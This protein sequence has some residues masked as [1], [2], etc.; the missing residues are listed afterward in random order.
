MSV[1]T[2]W[3][4][5]ASL[6]VL[7]NNRAIKKSYNYDVLMLKRS[8]KT[9]LKPNHLVFP[10]GMTERMDESQLWIKYFEK[11][12]INP[13]LLTD[14]TAV[15][16]NR[17][18][19]FRKSCS[20]SVAKEIT[21]R[22]SAIRETFEEVGLFLCRDKNNLNNKKEYGAFSEDFD[23]EHWQREVHNDPGKFLQLCEQL[24]VVPD[25]WSLY[26]WSVWLTPASDKKR[27]EAAFYLVAMNDKPNL[28]CEKDEVTEVMWK[29]PMEYIES[30]RNDEVWMQP[31]QIYELSRLAGV[32]EIENVQKF[33]SERNFKGS[34][35]F[36]PVKHKCK[37][38]L[39]GVLP[40]DDEYPE[41]PN[42]PRK[43]IEINANVDEFCSNVKRCH[44]I[45]TQTKETRAILNFEPFD[46][47]LKP[48]EIKNVVSSKL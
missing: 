13:K 36:L 11:F 7:A 17:P 46:G 6:I 9:S 28:I 37:N 19:I 18:G 47:H 20:N 5:S 42:E 4:E 21:L 35:L 43:I 3:K 8:P 38:G 41:N 25:L 26:E 39:V 2:L 33:A 31:P 40:G 24:K 48:M 14:L 10:G 44:R 12:G 16:G 1:K 45:I 34:T 23:R 32:S 29:N 22:I 15:H 30:Y 27:F